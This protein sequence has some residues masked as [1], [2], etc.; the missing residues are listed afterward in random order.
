MGGG[1]T[2]IP[3]ARVTALAAPS[4]RFV[5]DVAGVLCIAPPCYAGGRSTRMVEGITMRDAELGDEF[6]R[7]TGQLTTERW[8]I[9]LTIYLVFAALGELVEW[10]MYPGRGRLLLIALCAQVLVVAAG[11]LALSRETTHPRTAWIVLCADTS[12]CLIIAVYNAAVHGDL[13]YVLLS[14]LAFM[15][16][17]SMFIPWGMRFQLAMNAAV[18][19]AYL[20]ALIGGARVGPVPAYDF[21]AVAANTVLSALGAHYIDQYRRQLYAKAGALR[22]VNQRLRR[23]SEARTTLLSGLSHDMRTPVSVVTGYAEILGAN[24][25]LPEELRQ[26]VRSIEREALELL[27]LVDSVLDLARLEGGY[28]PFQRSTFRL[29]DALDPLRETTTDQL[30]DRK[31]RLR[32]D[33]PEEFTLDS[34]AGKVH[35]I[36]RNLLSNAVKFTSAGEI[37]VTAASADGGLHIVVSDTGAGIAPEHLELIFEAFHHIDPESGPHQPG[38]GFGLYMVKLLVDLLGGRIDVESAPGVGSRFRVWLPP[39]PPHAVAQSA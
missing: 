25:H 39:C 2:A 38:S 3:A 22:E 11:W 28:L 29:C 12:I 10:R 32:W 34:D 36:A 16:V 13:L 35:E 30:R 1:A 18:I 24:Q 37:T 9:G 8:R 14:Y 4:W 5:E 7:E 31:V 20:W 23:A 21:I 6:A 26:P 33:V 19:V 27:S 15:T 17:S